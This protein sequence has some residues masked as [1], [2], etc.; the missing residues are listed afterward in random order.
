MENNKSTDINLFN[1][2]ISKMIHSGGTL[3]SLLSKL[4]GPLIK[5]AVLLAKNFLAQLGITAAAPA[6]DAGIQKKIPGSGTAT[7]IMKKWT[8]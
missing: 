4:A 1:A 7:L 8:I 2:Q 3:G 6:V 5:V